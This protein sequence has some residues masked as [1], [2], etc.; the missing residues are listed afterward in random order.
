M[1]KR[2]VAII[3]GRMSSSRLFEKLLVDI[4]DFSSIDLSLKEQ[5][6][7]NGLV[8]GQRSSS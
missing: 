5:V 1:T 2:V 6:I 8:N 7:G 4:A 3:Q